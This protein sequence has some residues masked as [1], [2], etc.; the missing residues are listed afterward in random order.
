MKWKYLK[1]NL[2]LQFA[3]LLFAPA[4]QYSTNVQAVDITVQ[5]AVRGAR[6]LLSHMKSLRIETMFNHFYDQTLKGSQSLTEEQI[7]PD[8]ASYQNGL[9]LD[10]QLITIKVPKTCIVMLIMRHWI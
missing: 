3:Y 7:L 4:K 5:E 1:C 8:I 6:L 9:I 10:H 2:D